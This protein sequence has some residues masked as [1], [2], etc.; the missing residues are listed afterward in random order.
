V[1]LRHAPAALDWLWLLHGTLRVL[2]HD[3]HELVVENLLLRQ[4]P[5]VA[6]RA[7]PRPR[8][9]RGDRLFWIMIRRV[10]ADWRRHLVVVRPETVLRW[11]RRGWRLVWWWRSRRPTGRRRVP[12]EVRDLIASMSRDNPLWGTERLRGELRKL[13]IAVSSGSIRRHRW[14]R[15]AR[16]PSQTWRTFL[17]NPA[18]QIWA[19][20]LCVVRTLT[21]KTLYVL[22]VIAHDR[23]ELVHLAVTA[24]RTTAWVWRQLVEAT[25][26]DRRP[27]HLARDRGAVYGGDFIR[28][29]KWLGIETVL[30]PVRAPRANAIAERVVRTLRTECLDHVLVVNE[31][32]LRAVLAEY[33]GY[34]NRERPHRTLRL[35]APAPIPR[36]ATDRSASA[37]SRA[38]ST[39]CTRAPPDHEGVLR[40]PTPQRWPALAWRSR[41]SICGPSDCIVSLAVAAPS[42]TLLYAGPNSPWISECRAEMGRALSRSAASFQTAS[43]SQGWRDRWN[44]AESIWVLR[45]ATVAPILNE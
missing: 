9:R 32:H 18:A 40:P 4:Q 25:A 22:V 36:S 2:P 31:R 33:V 27:R 21:F 35:E 16:P 38:A 39:T 41:S 5:T 14:R 13:G 29:A 44:S 45:T 23:R 43:G 6:L 10:C 15:P 8:L 30:T 24:H 20:D 12:R 26:W 34:Y 3:R 7:R 37:A 17:R 28:R 1:S 42:F 11:H 19:A